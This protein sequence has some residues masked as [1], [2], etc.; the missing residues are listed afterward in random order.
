MAMFRKRGAKWQATVRRKGFDTQIKTFI[1]KHDAVRWAREQELLLDRGSIA[2]HSDLRDL[3]FS[4]LLLRYQNEITPAKRARESETVHLRQIIRH[5]ISQITISRMRSE[6]IAQFRDDRLKSVSAPTVRKEV[7]L[8]GSIFSVALREWGLTGIVNPVQ[9]IKK[10]PNGLARERRLNSDEQR[11]FDDALNLCRNATAV[12]VIKFAKAT[13]MRRSEILGLKVADIDLDN[14][15]ARLA[16]TK[17]GLSRVVP[18][19]PIARS[20]ITVRLPPKPDGAIFPISPNALRLAFVR[21]CKRASVINFT[22]HDLRHEAIS[23][24]IENGLSIPEVALI[25]GHKDT[26]MLA[27]YTHLRPEIVSEKLSRVC[28]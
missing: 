5:R 17:N 4:A 13:A 15:T 24:F 6:H 27:R 25:S 19:S 26:R 9:G 16:L 3:P 8:I 20:L 28:A 23:S 12:A 22:F 18:L 1:K 14:S 10:P 11:R 7:T 2:S 21:V